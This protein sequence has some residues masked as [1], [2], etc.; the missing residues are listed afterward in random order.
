MVVVHSLLIFS[1][2][3]SALTGPTPNEDILMTVKTKN[4]LRAFC[5]VGIFCFA[6]LGVG[7]L[8]PVHI[9]G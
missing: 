2:L 9:L 3:G 7:L 4:E 1:P 5:I 6:V 8:A